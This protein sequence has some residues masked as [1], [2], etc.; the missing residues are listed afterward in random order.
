MIA[1]NVR[2]SIETALESLRAERARIDGAIAK[3]EAVLG[4]PTSLEELDNE[5]MV[6]QR[7]RSTAGWTPEKR[8]AA[9]ER[10]ERYWAEQR[11][12][13]DGGPGRSASASRRKKRSTEGWTPEKRRA[14]ADRMR[15]YWAER[16]TDGDAERQPA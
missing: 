15:R 4:S 1:E 16:K 7:K 3:L 9:A 14:A 2:D 6:S 12:A 11:A 10:M 13:Q 5:A 8:R